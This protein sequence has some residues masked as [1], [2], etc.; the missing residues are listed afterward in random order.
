MTKEEIF[1]VWAPQDVLWSPW[2]KPVLFACMPAALAQTTPST[3]T[4]T[5][6]AEWAP[7]ADSGVVIVLDL[8]GAD[9]VAAGLA[10]AAL[11]YRPVPLYNA[12]PAP[13]APPFQPAASTG[14]TGTVAATASLAEGLAAVDLQPVMTALQLGAVELRQRTLAPNAPPA[15]LLDWNRHRGRVTLTEGKFDNRSVSFTTD[16]PSGNFL[17]AHGFRRV[18]LVHPGPGPGRLVY[19]FLREEQPQA[20]LAHTLRQWQDSGLAIEFCRL[21]D[22]SPPFPLQ[23]QRPSWFRWI[24][25]R[26]IAAFGLRRN[27]SGGFGHWVP[28]TSA[29]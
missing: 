21:D 27:P 26:V 24:G 17:L 29:G 25:Q 16:F 1:N 11:G 6:T 23:V 22:P 7:P 20:D 8:P 2:A 9:G 14:N 4:T 5:S 15:F 10:L 3:P 19:T 18:L 28:D 13:V 12:I